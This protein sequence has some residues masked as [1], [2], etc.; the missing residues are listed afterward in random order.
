MFKLK[1]IKGRSFTGFGVK[2]TSEKPEVQTDAKEL[3]DKLIATG[4]FTAVMMSESTNALT[5]GEKPLSKMTE[6]EL[7][8]YAEEN[9]INLT[10]LSKKS[11]KLAKIQ[12]MLAADDG[13]SLFDEDI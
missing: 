2:A 10:G 8:V 13:G 11:D 3:Y 1:L 12:E 4:R 9:G 7:E 6:K 5:A